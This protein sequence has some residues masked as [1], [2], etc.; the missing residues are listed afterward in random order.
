MV[1]VGS[2]GGP[3]AFGVLLAGLPATLPVP[4]L[5]ALHIPQEYTAALAARLERGSSLEVIESL[6]R[7]PLRPGLAVLAR[8]GQHLSV[9]RDGAE[10]VAVTRN[11]PRTSLYVPSVDVLFES[12]ARACG[13]GTIAVVLSGMGNDGRDGAAAVRA[14]GGQV[15]TQAAPSCVIDGMPRAVREAGLSH[16]DVMLEDVARTIVDVLAGRAAQATIEAH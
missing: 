8:G 9:R 15:I 7:V 14:Q 2:T 13:A 11:E 16:A 1:V 4:V 5:L 10:L 3:Q 12:A 6:A